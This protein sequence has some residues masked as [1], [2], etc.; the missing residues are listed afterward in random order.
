MGDLAR[1]RLPVGDPE[2]TPRPL[3]QHTCCEV[4]VKR[5]GLE[6]Y[7]ELNFATSGAWAA[8]AFERYR[9]GAPLVDDALDPG[10]RV[11]SARDTV[12]LQ[13]SIPLDRLWA[14]DACSRLTLAL[15][16]VIEERDLGLT[17]WAL[18]HPAGKPDFHHPEAFALELEARE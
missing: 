4:F 18:V 14:S 9:A 6:S 10:I 8:Y 13:A 11:Q 2:H 15:A 12:E 3:W 7:R 1:V 16:A 5:A 17:Y